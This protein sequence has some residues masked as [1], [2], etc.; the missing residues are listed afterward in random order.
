MGAVGGLRF[1]VRDSHLIGQRVHDD[2]VRHQPEWVD[3]AHQDV[4][5]DLVELN[6]LEE[7]AEHFLQSDVLGIEVD[8]ERKKVC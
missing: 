2:R 4:R 8:L 6:V 7:V 1:G 5:R 3:L